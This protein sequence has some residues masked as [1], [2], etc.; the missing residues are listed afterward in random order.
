VPRG[1]GE[2]NQDDAWRIGAPRKYQAAKVFVLSQEY[3]LLCKR[4]VQHILVH[5][6]VLELAYGE[7]I[8][9][10]R[11]ESANGSEIAAFVREETHWPNLW[12]TEFQDGFV[13]DGVGCVRQRCA[14]VVGS[15]P[16]VCIQEIFDRG[17]FA[18]LAQ[19]KF[20]GYPRSANHGFALHDARIDLDPVHRGDSASIVPDAGAAALPV[21]AEKPM[22]EELCGNAG[23]G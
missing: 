5:G 3:P 13:R 19:H 22:A 11:P 1:G 20:N 18:K 4:K 8:V 23:V 10:A 2:S 14:N 16:G 9:T 7:H 21:A 12:G 15:Q 17:A 6:T